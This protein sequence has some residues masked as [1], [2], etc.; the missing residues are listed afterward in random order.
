MQYFI[1]EFLNLKVSIITVKGKEYISFQSV[2][3][4]INFSETSFEERG[5][6]CCLLLKLLS[7]IWMKPL[8]KSSHNFPTLN[9]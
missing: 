4:W 9:K 5:G 2:C 7:A 1:L 8:T 6:T 3:I